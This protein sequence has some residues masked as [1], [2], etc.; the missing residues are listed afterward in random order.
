E[1]ARDGQLLRR[2]AM[3]QEENAFAALMRRHGPMVL[4]VSQRV[5]HHRHDAEDVFQATFLL[6]ARKAKSLRKPDSVGSRLHGGAHRLA[7]QDKTRAC[8]RRAR[9]ERAGARP[10]T[11]PGFEAAWRELLAVL[12]EE[13]QALPE[14]LRSALV[15]CC[16]EGHTQEEAGRVLGCP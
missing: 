4:S 8:R 15:L 2:F 16:L 12:D 14:K 5:L 11:P 13:V 9:E 3:H 6:L 7:T 10:L 1:T